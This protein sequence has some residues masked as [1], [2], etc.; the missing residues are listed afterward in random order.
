MSFDAH[1]AVCFDSFSQSLIFFDDFE[2]DALKDLWDSVGSA[3]G[4]AVVVD[5]QTGG[6]LRM[7]PDNNDADNWL[8]SWNEIRSLHV[9]KKVVMEVRLRESNEQGI[10][11]NIYLRFDGNSF[12]LLWNG[13][14]NWTAVC[15]N[16]GVATQVD[17][18]ISPVSGVF[19]VLRIECTPTAVSFFID[20]VE[21]ANS[22]IITN[23]PNDAGDFLQP[24]ILVVNDNEGVS[25]Y[26]DV[27][28][29]YIRQE[30]G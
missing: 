5:A 15:E 18:G 4:S 21:T 23:I 2:G 13:T 9:D 10:S 27:D 1:E 12:V 7:T 14:G 17:T 11:T 20:G 26:V 16:G 25:E 22:P 24:Y 28:Y 29:I 30:R 6:V 19:Q 8:L 3:G